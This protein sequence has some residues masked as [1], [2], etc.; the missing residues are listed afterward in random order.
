MMLPWRSIPIGGTIFEPGSSI[1]YRTGDW[2][3]QRKPVVDHEKCIMCLFCWIFCPDASIVRAEN[4]VEVDYY[5][6][7]GCGVCESECPVKA[8]RMV[9]E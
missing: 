2:R 1:E 3:V 6:C 8:I 7:K 5:H 4:R 9:E